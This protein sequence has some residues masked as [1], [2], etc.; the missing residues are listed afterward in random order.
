MNTI[1][2]LSYDNIFL[3]RRGL[4]TPL[5]FDNDDSAVI[6]SLPTKNLRGGPENRLSRRP[7]KP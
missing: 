1:T 3:Y 4:P 6:L 2:A 7:A 5:G